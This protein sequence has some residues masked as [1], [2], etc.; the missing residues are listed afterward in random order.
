[1][2]N[3]LNCFN[4]AFRKGYT[5]VLLPFLQPANNFRSEN[6]VH[7]AKNIVHSQADADE[8]SFVCEMK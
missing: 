1:M 7:Y 5:L 4:K 3:D 6:I 2:Q 8:R